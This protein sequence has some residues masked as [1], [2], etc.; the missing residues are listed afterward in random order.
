MRGMPFPSAGLCLT[1]SW[2]DSCPWGGSRA[3]GVS[4]ARAGRAAGAAASQTQHV[5]YFD[6]EQ[7]RHQEGTGGVL[8]A[9]LFPLIKLPVTRGEALFS[10]QWC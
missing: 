8:G 10:N 6:K 4:A 7:G 3:A 2:C 1:R 5:Y 9:A